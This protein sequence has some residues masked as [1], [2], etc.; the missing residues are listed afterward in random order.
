MVQNC[1]FLTQP[2]LTTT[3]IDD[4]NRRGTKLSLAVLG[5]VDF[6]IV[7]ALINILRELLIFIIVT[8]Q[9]ILAKNDTWESIFFFAKICTK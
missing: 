5:N 8:H 4:S 6:Q 2:K 7:V 3:A 9:N 1:S